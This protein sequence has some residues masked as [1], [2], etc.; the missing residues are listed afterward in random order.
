MFRWHFKQL[1]ERHQSGTPANSLIPMSVAGESFWLLL[2]LVVMH[3]H[4]FLN[5]LITRLKPKNLQ[6]LLVFCR[7]QRQLSFFLWCL[8]ALKLW[9][10]LKQK[11]WRCKQSETRK[12]GELKRRNLGS[13][14]Y[15][16]KMWIKII[17]KYKMDLKLKLWTFKEKTAIKNCSKLC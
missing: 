7:S 15:I 4:P 1:A 8:K 3:H 2:L 16:H 12:F 13:Y 14:K 6:N 10:T 17:Q 5:G 11:S 9:R